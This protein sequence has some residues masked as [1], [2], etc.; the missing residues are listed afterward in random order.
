MSLE[1][2]TPAASAQPAQTQ[3]APASAPASGTSQAGQPASQTASTQSSTSAAKPFDAVSAQADYTR[4]TQELAEQRKALE[5]EKT[6]FQQR[7]NGL[8][9]MS[10]QAPAIPGVNPYAPN[11]YQV[12]QMPQQAPQHVPMPQNQ[13]QQQAMYQGLVEQFGQEG[14]RTVWN[15][16]QQQTQQ[17]QQQTAQMQFSTRYQMEYEKASEK[18]GDKMKEYDYADPY[19]GQFAGNHIIDT[20]ANNKQFTLDMAWRAFNAEDP[21]KKEQ[22]LRD[23][24]YAEIQQKTQQT[25]ESSHAQPAASGS[26]HARTF[27]EALEQA[28][29]SLGVTLG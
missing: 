3:A 9:R 21:S 15:L 19:T 25:P 20:L 8:N 4:K 26:G 7:L 29:K 22:E 2:G 23:K 13:L 1:Q 11:P 10:V 5:A 17:I 14:A 6:A 24:V 12:Q 16:V 28:E 18:F 27:R